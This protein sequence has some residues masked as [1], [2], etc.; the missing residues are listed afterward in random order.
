MNG[1]YWNFTK[2]TPPRLVLQLSG[3]AFIF[4]SMTM[5]FNATD[6]FT[7]LKAI[8]M[9]IAGTILWIL[10]EHVSNGDYFKEFKKT[11][12]NDEQFKKSIA[13][14]IKEN[15]VLEEEEENDSIYG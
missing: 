12:E 14:Y 3:A 2:G 8:L 1:N 10:R 6:T 5:F 4:Y 15:Y 7:L 9:F 13:E 11:I